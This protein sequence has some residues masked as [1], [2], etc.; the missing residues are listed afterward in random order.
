MEPGYSPATT[1][2]GVA[3]RRLL[4][5]RNPFPLI[6]I[7]RGNDQPWQPV[8]LHEV[9]H[10][11]QADLGIWEENRSAVGHRMWRAVSDPAVVSVYRRWHKEIFADLAALLLGGPASAW[12]MMSF[13]AHPAPKTL[14]YRPGGVHPTGYLRVLIL[15]EMLERMGF[16]GDAA[17]MRRIW[18]RLY[19]PAQ[20]HR[21]PATLLRAS[22]KTI[23]V[24]VDEIAFQP[25]RNLA[26]RALA[27]VIPFSIQDEQS[28][29]QGS[30]MFARGVLPQDLPAR[31]G[32][33]RLV[34]A[35][36]GGR[37]GAT[38]RNFD[39][40]SIIPNKPA[41]GSSAGNKR[42]GRVR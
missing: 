22:G 2:R 7:P 31:F 14:T 1:R 5:E 21:I 12:G 15:S 11:L 3:L 8:F 13:L 24:V 17:L 6:R 30:R 16:E 9:A 20:G 40:A 37:P 34:R 25:R 10:N 38:L 42:R 19:Q 41:S 18:R 39:S 29:R 26:Q 28:I 33:R 32:G 36:S 4:G 27:D 23:P 35:Y